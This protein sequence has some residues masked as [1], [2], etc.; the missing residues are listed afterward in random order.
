MDRIDRWV[1]STALIRIVAQNDNAL[2]S[3]SVSSSSFTDSDFPVFVKSE[4][5]R[6]GI[7]GE[8]LCFE[9]AE[10]AAVMNLELTER[11]IRAVRELGVM[12]TL[13]HFGNSLFS[14]S[15]LKA[16]PVDYPKKD[17]SFMHGSDSSAVDNASSKP[18]IISRTC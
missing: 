17:G 13:D 16:L 5:Q 18:F 11:F 14:F 10:A 8:G 7:S 3:I 6:A 2:I 1:I 4:L 9:I 12:I 15:G